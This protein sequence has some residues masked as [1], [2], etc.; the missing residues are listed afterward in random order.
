M[1]ILTGFYAFIDIVFPTGLGG[2]D[3]FRGRLFQLS[4]RCTDFTIG[5]GFANVPRRHHGRRSYI[6]LKEVRP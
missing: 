6:V 2:K 3:G 1:S 5:D 4:L